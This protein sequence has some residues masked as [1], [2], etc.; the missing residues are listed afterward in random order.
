MAKKSTGIVREVDKWGRTKVPGVPT[1]RLFPPEFR[2][3]KIP[4]PSRVSINKAGE[5]ALEEEQRTGKVDL[6]NPNIVDTSLWDGFME[7]IPYEC[8]E[9]DGK[10]MEFFAVFTK[11]IVKESNCKD[12]CLDGFYSRQGNNKSMLPETKLVWLTN[13]WMKYLKRSVD[14]PNYEPVYTNAVYTM[15]QWERNGGFKGRAEGQEI[16]YEVYKRFLQENQPTRSLPCRLPQNRD[17]A[18]NLE[19]EEG[20]MITEPCAYAEVEGE[21]RPFYLM[22]SKRKDQYRGYFCK[23]EGV[24]S[25]QGDNIFDISLEKQNW[26][27]TEHILWRDHITPPPYSD[28]DYEIL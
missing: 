22:F 2:S 28:W 13:R 10:P 16:S 27:S 17:G 3:Y 1:I 4:L 9:V 26:I 6:Y 14:Y 5:L 24:Y 21:Q 7:G 23:F 25:A 15:E 20:F 19:F 12:Y 11:A 8:D 18:V